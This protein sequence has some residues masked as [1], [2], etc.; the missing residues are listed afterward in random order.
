MPSAR[1]LRRNRCGR[2]PYFRAH[3]QTPPARPFALIIPIIALLIPI[4]AILVKH[5]ERMATMGGAAAQPEAVRLLTETL[6]RQ[7][8]RQ[9][10]LQRRVETLEAAMIDRDLA[11]RAGTPLHAAPAA[12]ARIGLPDED[13]PSADAAP[14]AP[15]RVRA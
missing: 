3:R 2:T 12:P 5:R 14:A 13:A 6:E 7:H 8:E 1:R 10:A 11:A 4:V 15:T 9:T